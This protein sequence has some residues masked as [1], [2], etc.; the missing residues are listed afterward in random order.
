[1]NKQ[2]MIMTRME[3]MQVQI[4]NTC[5]VTYETWNLSCVNFH[6]TIAVDDIATKNYI[7]LMTDNV[8]QSM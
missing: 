7:D 6:R 3:D 1:M 2:I 5:K 8:E 4:L